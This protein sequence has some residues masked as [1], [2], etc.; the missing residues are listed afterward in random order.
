M[1]QISAHLMIELCAFSLFNYSDYIKP[2]GG[3]ILFYYYIVINSTLLQEF[4][5]R[6]EEKTTSFK[7]KLKKMTRGG[8][9]KAIYAIRL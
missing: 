6:L 3:F 4:N 8:F 2:F 9:H 1:V 7:Q 5:S